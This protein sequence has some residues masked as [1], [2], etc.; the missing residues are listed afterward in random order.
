MNNE[1]LDNIYKYYESVSKEYND[2]KYYNKKDEN[3]NSLML[4]EIM[5]NFITDYF[6]GNKKEHNLPNVVSDA[7]FKSINQPT[8]YHGFTKYDYPIKYL[9]DNKY[10]YGRGN[11]GGGFYT[12]SIFEDALKYTNKYDGQSPD[13]VI[14]CKLENGRL[15]MVSYEDIE[16]CCSALIG[17]FT[18]R[19]TPKS[20]MN[21]VQKLIDY[22]DT[23]EDKKTVDNFKFEIAT[24]PSTL[25]I[26]LGYNCVVKTDLNDEEHEDKWFNVILD[27]SLLIVPES[28]ALKVQKKMNEVTGEKG[29]VYAFNYKSLEDLDIDENQGQKV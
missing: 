24:N 9:T 19:D 15:N 10:H 29:K 12:S 26:L 4:Q 21:K 6:F 5:F 13:K 20:M 11:Y 7:D 17:E 16:D 3:G 27:R 22:L 18:F 2:V 25:A 1:D 28:D 23:F 8:I 14:S